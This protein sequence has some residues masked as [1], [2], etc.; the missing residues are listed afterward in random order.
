MTQTAPGPLRVSANG[1]YLVDQNGVPFFWLGDT[2]WQL[3][4]D[5]TLP[6]VDMILAGRAHQGFTVVQVMLTGTG[7][8]TRPN[9][10]GERPWSN[11][12]PATPNEAYFKNVD[13]VLELARRHGL[14]VALYL[15]HNLQHNDLTPANARAYARWVA[16]RYRGLPNLLWAFVTEVPL[17]DHLPLIRE[18]AAGVQEGDGGQHLISYHPDPVSPALSSGEIHTEPWLA[19]NMI[20]VWRWYEGIYGMVTRDYHRAPA[21]PV[22]MAEA[23]YEDETDSEYGFVISPLLVR[24]QAYW[25]CLSG[26][27]HS[28]GHSDSWR[29][30]LPPKAWLDAPGAQ[31][32]GVLKRLFTAHE[33][34]TLVPDQS[35][36]RSF[37]HPGTALH[38]AARAGDGRW[39]LVY[40]S[41]PDVITANTSKLA[42]G[43]DVAFTWIDPRDGSAFPIGHSPSGTAPTLT[44][45]QGWEDA[46]LLMEVQAA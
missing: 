15:S 33:W 29:G 19:F 40:F 41:S 43:G 32:L 11:N 12:D 39:A 6:D 44:T 21:K 45:P 38:T 8:G 4:R 34:W 7:D 46:V 28:Y 18:L 3:A 36:I 1:R 31:Q 16:R 24:K 14:V 10:A 22:V 25:S 37:A 27:F 13:A 17:A 2:Q 20:Q 5:F 42:Q 35:L 23:T 26:G 9:L 30:P